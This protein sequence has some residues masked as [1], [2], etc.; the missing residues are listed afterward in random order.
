MVRLSAC[1]SLGRGF[2]DGG[3][4]GG[5]VDD[6]FVGGEGGQQGLQGE[7]VDRAGVAAAGLVQQ[8]GGVVGEQGVGSSGQV[9]VVAQVVGGLFQG[10]AGHV[11]AHGDAL[12]EGGEHAEFDLAAQV[13]W[14]TSRQAS[15]Q[16]LS[17]SWLVSMRMASSW[18]WSS[19]WPSSMT[20][21]GVRPR[22]AASVASA[23][24]TATVL[25]TPTSPVSTPRACWS[26][27]Q[28]MRATASAWAVWRCSIWGA[29]SRP[30]GILVNP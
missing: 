10:H 2:G 5:L 24:W 18:S 3:A 23:A 19:R 15:G 9:E 4:G 28:V 12:V 26:M 16:R 14:P 22:S 1:C 29:S 7:V 27:H 17:R 13:G 30:N 21:T 6:A 8:R 11:V 25:P 20:S